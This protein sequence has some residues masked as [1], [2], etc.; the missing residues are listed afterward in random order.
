MK[1]KTHD[2]IKHFTAGR[3]IECCED[4]STYHPET[5]EHN[6]EIPEEFLYSKDSSVGRKLLDVLD[7]FDM[8]G[9]QDACYMKGQA[10][11]YKKILKFLNDLK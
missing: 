1:E 5:F 4:F 2:E 8:D 10:D 3:F 11:A 7:Y 6:I 9:M